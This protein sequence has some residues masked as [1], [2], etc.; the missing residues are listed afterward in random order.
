MGIGAIAFFWPF[1]EGW[2][3]RRFRMPDAV[4]VLIGV[5]AFLCFLAFTVWE[6]LAV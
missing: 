2:L 4:S 5:L 1:I 6:S 3:K